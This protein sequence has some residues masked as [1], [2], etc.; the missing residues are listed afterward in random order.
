MQ[1]H[2]SGGDH[3][4]NLNFVSTFAF[5]MQ[6]NTNPLTSN[7]FKTMKKLVLA[8]FVFFLFCAGKAFSQTVYITQNGQYYHTAKCKNVGKTATKKNLYDVQQ[9]GYRP[10]KICKPPTKA[11]KTPAK[12]PAAKPKPK[13]VAAPPK[14]G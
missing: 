6:M 2:I 12:K 9:L 8:S 14:K 11:G 3:L 1:V 4:V 13:A 5:S 10:C 7:H